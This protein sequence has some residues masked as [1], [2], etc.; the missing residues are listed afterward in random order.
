[1]LHQLNSWAIARGC[2]QHD[3]TRSFRIVLVGK[4][5]TTTTQPHGTSW[6]GFA[7]TDAEVRTSAKV[8]Y[9]P[10]YM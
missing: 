8:V 9:I 6:C 4:P 5:E 7:E 3:G 10:T 2:L 1:M